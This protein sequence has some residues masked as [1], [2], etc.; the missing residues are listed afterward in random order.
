LQRNCGVGFRTVQRMLSS[1]WPEPRRKPRPQ[2]TRLDTDPRQC[3]AIVDRLTFGGNTI[4]T[5]TDSYRL[6]QPALKPS[7]TLRA[8]H[9]GVRLG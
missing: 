1:A 3:V 8:D 2:A 4:N 5:G 7:I 9:H 6:A